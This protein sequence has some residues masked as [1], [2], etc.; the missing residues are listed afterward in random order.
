MKMS[1]LRWNMLEVFL[2]IC[3]Y[4]FFVLD[5]LKNF[6]NVRFQ[7]AKHSPLFK[8]KIRN[9]ISTRYDKIMLPICTVR[10]FAQNVT[11]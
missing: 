8:I 4:R 2:C 9:M 10:T 11:N 7:K 6:V 5:L 3:R 1:A